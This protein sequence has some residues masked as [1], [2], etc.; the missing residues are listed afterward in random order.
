VIYFNIS[1]ATGEEMCS[2]INT[3]QKEH[4]IHW[5]KCVSIC[6]VGARAMQ[7]TMSGMVDDIKTLVTAFSTVKQ[8]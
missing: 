3:Y 2:D 4:E 6:T 8:L 5:Q 7:G 1:H